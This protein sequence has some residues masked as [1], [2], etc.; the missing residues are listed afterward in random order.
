MLAP[1]HWH[2]EISSKCTLACPRCARQEMPDNLVNTEL[3]LT[4]FKKNFTPNFILQHVERITLCGDDGDPIYAHDFLDI[5]KYIKSIKNVSLLIITNGSYKKLEWWRELA[6]VL[7]DVDQLHFSLD[8]WDQASNEL[9]RVNSDWD[10][11]MLGVNTIS[12]YSNCYMVWDAIGFKFNEDKIDHMRSLAAHLGFD[13]F[14]L[15]KSTKFGSKYPGIYGT[16]DTLEPSINFISS[17]HRF[18]REFT[19][20]SDKIFVKVWLDTNLK[21]FNKTEIVNDSIKPLCHVGNKGLFINNSHWMNLG[22]KFNLYH[23]L[24]EDIISLDFWKKDFTNNS[25]E[26]SMK[27]NKDIVTEKYAT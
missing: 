7:T 12:K 15:T 13:L 18:E 24:L 17:S 23:N 21:F 2:I 4:F 11:I 27:C 25:L 3:D 6:S 10:S 5:V 14:Q 19:Q 1:W 16:K 8:G 22:K 20:L 26:C 9:Y